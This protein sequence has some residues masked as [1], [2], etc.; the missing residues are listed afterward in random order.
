MPFAV[1]VAREDG[2]V[3]IAVEG[4]GAGRDL[5]RQITPALEESAGI[6]DQRLLLDLRE[7]QVTEMPPADMHSFEIDVARREGMRGA[8]AR[9]AVLASNDLLFGIAR[10]FQAIRA[11]SRVAYGVFRD[12]AEADAWLAASTE[13]SPP[14][15]LR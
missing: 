4:R 11:Q 3:R 7:A 6:G 5:L 12:P 2:V 8:G 14:P 13:E 10:M 1:R 9:A 15:P